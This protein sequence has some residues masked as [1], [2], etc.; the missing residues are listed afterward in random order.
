VVV[1]AFKLRSHAGETSQLLFTDEAWHRIALAFALSPRELE[2]VR[3]IFDDHKEAAI[4][5]ALGISPHT[6]HTYLARVY[7]K[8]HV[9]S[10]VQL[11]V[12]VVQHENGHS[13]PPG[14]V[15]SHRSRAPHHGRSLRAVPISPGSV[16]I[17]ARQNGD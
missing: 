6:V 2:I 11:V 14:R 3:Q 17:L 13:L 7:H 9:T 4:A 15:R 8:L 10:R 5:Q 1:N 16:P 12:R